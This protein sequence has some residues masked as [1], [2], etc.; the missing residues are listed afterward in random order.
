[1]FKKPL[2]FLKKDLLLDSSY[3]LSFV[4]SIFGVLVSVL[5]Y[6]FIDKLFGQR[7]VT[8]LEEFGVNY[9][10]YVL[11]S[12]AFFS[13]IGIGLGSFSE[14]IQI[15]QTQGTL[16]AILLTPT[17][18]STFLFSLTAWNLILATIEM[19]FTLSWEFIYLKSTSHTLIFCPPLLS[20]S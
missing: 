9:F 3:N 15:E 2:A 17:K 12:M 5:S 8:N 19:A 6:F 18:I 13:Y 7:M 16:E 20:S 4:F 11:L 10:S 14:R 1:M